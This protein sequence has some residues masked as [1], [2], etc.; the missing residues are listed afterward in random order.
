MTLWHRNKT[1]LAIIPGIPD[2]KEGCNNSMEGKANLPESSWLNI[3]YH[4][5]YHRSSLR[6]PQTD[7][8]QTHPK[9]FYLRLPRRHSLASQTQESLLKWIRKRRLSYL[10][11]QI[12]GVS[13]KWRIIL[14]N[15][16]LINRILIIS[17]DLWKVKGVKTIEMFEKISFL[18]YVIF[19][20]TKPGII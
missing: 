11:F 19:I 5:L 12:S 2:G 18:L 13:R 9:S 6:C 8:H 20:S 4:E 1:F 16:Y 17:S 3:W 7:Y 15:K 10:Y 14:L